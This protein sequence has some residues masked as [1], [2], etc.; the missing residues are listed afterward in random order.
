MKTIVLLECDCGCKLEP[1]INDW[2]YIKIGKYTIDFVL[3]PNCK[4]F[5]QPIIVVNEL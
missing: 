3:C 4:F 1:E 2:K 5:V